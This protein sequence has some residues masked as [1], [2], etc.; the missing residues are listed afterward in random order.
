MIEP[1]LIGIPG[2]LAAACGLAAALELVRWRGGRRLFIPSTLRDGHPIALRLGTPA[3]VWLVGRYAGE[4][5][6]VSKCERAL[7][8]AR[9]AQIVDAHDAGRSIMELAGEYGLSM[10][11]VSNAIRRG[12]DSE[13]NPQADLF[14]RLRA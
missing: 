12:R 10:R 1:R 8:L 4:T 13:Y 7:M 14:D 11:S 5:I 2:D 9:D 3:F 6:A